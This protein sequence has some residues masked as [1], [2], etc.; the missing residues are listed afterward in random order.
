M[1]KC[2]WLRRGGSCKVSSAPE[3]T[4]HSNTAN[5]DLQ[6]FFTVVVIL[7]QRC[8]GPL[9]MPATPLFTLIYK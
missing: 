2:F 9:I 1:T 4:G 8:Y 3:A 5:S 6:V 7:V